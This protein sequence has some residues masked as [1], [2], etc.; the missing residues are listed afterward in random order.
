MH[1]KDNFV[2]LGVF[3]VELE[4]QLPEVEHFS[5]KLPQ[6]SKDADQTEGTVRQPKVAVRLEVSGCSRAS[7][8]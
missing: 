5:R 8:R 3:A 7:V 2:T 6:G 4:Y 1:E